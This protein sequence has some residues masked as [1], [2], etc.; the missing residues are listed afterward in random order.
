MALNI[1]QGQVEIDSQGAGQGQWTE[2]YQEE[3][4]R[5]G[6]CLQD[7]LNRTLAKERQGAK[8][9]RVGDEEFHQILTAYQG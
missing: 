2:N 3:T 4:L 6:A 8:I 7:Q 9:P 5:L 1:Q